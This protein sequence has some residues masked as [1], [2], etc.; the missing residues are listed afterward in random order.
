MSRCVQAHHELIRELI[1]E[2][3]LYEVKTVGDAF[4]VTTTSAQNA[5]LFALDV[6]TTLFDYDWDWSAADDFYKETTLMFTKAMDGSMVNT[7]DDYS[8]MWNGIRVRVG[9]HYGKGDVTY[10]EVSKGYDYYGNVVNIASRIEALAHGGQVVVSEDLLDALPAPLD[11][12]LAVATLLGTFPLR[13][14]A[15]P[16]AL[17]E[18]K[19]TALQGRTFPPLRVDLANADLSGAGGVNMSTRSP[20]NKTGLRL[21]MNMMEMQGEDR[22]GS[23]NSAASFKS[24]RRPM[25]QVAEDFARGHAMVRSGALPLEVVTQQLLMLHCVLEDL[26]KPLAAQQF[27][28]VTKALA[29]GWGVTPPNGKSDF[30]SS[31]LRLVQR[32]SETTQVL[33]HLSQPHA[34]SQRSP[35]SPRGMEDEVLEMDVV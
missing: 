7:D 34:V 24:D 19:P 15:E 10:D 5:L 3:D 18:F 23:E 31:G 25:E 8:D 9:V 1:H 26:L 17:V 14:V 32:M 6:Q 13:G 11:P 16:P 21:D 4:M 33:T 29:K 2:H 27:S 22:R 12:S 20:R 28:T 30:G 35:R